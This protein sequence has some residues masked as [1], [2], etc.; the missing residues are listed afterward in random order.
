[1]WLLE[2]STLKACPH[3]TFQPVQT[4]SM[5][6]HRQLKPVQTKASLM[7]HNHVEGNE[8]ISLIVYCIFLLVCVVPGSTGSANVAN[9]CLGSIH[10]LPT[11]FL[12]DVQVCH[13]RKDTT[14][15]VFD[16]I[17]SP[18]LNLDLSPS[19]SPMNTVIS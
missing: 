11:I 16:L 5:N 18:T 13:Q 8:R 9:S 2:N 15:V 7:F 3:C 1:M 12:S 19:P 14:L 17:L 4:G 10:C 6:P